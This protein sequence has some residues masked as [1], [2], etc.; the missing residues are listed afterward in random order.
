MPFDVEWKVYISR[1]EAQ[2][3]L[4]MFEATI[5]ATIRNAGEIVRR[6]NGYI[7]F[8]MFDNYHTIRYEEG[9]FNLRDALEKEIKRVAKE[10]A[11]KQKTTEVEIYPEELNW[12]YLE[13]V[14]AGIVAS[15]L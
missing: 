6:L 13:S 4:D 12:E 2:L 10:K 7:W 15:K 5:K 11:F 9:F 14:L 1:R 3:Y 8:D